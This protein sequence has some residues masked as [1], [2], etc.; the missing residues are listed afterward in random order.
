MPNVTVNIV[1]DSIEE[2]RS[3]FAD[4]VGPTGHVLTTSYPKTDTITVA[5][6]SRPAT[7]SVVLAAATTAPQA[8]VAPPAPASASS[9]EDLVKRVHAEVNELI[10]RVPSGAGAVKSKEILLKHGYSRIRDVNDAAKA[11]AIIAD[12]RAA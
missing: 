9:P 3:F 1:F 10:K 5:E 7:A 11:E 8:T 12:L 2:A 6:S 4:S